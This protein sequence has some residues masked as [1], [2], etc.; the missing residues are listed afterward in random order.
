MIGWRR[1]SLINIDKNRVKF[2]NT[3]SNVWG[4][5]NL[6]SFS[7]LVASHGDR[8]Q[9]TSVTHDYITTL[10]VGEHFF[11]YRYVVREPLV[12]Q[13][14]ALKQHEAQEKPEESYQLFAV[15]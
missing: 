8:T 12:K 13:L 2:G 10:G 1:L 11:N 14:E 6:L 5:Q 4:E 15:S 3:N 9:P 7:L